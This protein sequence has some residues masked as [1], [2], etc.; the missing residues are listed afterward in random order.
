MRSALYLQGR[1]DSRKGCPGVGAGVA[2]VAFD[3]AA[4]DGIGE[5]ARALALDHGQKLRCV[6]HSGA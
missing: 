5:H 3:E 6:G 4:T 2:D 1:G